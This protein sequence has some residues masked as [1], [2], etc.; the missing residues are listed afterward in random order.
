MNDFRLSNYKGKIPKQVVSIDELNILENTLP[1][2]EHLPDGRARD[3]T[4]GN[5]D[6]N[7]E[8]S[9]Y[10]VAG[11]DKELIVKSLKEASEIVGV[12]YATLSKKLDASV[13]A[14]VNDY[15]TRRIGVF[16]ATQ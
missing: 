5:I 10:L 1:M 2:S 12:H 7:N 6:H 16:G 9:V 8:S 3:I 14:E 11:S 15:S 13:M 4:T